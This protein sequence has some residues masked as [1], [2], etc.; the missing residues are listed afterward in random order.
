MESFKF[1]HVDSVYRNKETLLVKLWSEHHLQLA[2]LRHVDS[3]S[4]ELKERL[5][6][7]GPKSRVI[8]LNRRI[9]I[10]DYSTLM[11]QQMF[12]FCSL[13][14]GG[15]GVTVLDS[16][17]ALQQ[18]NYFLCHPKEKEVPKDLE[19]EDERSLI[20]S[21]SGGESYSYHVSIEAT[22][23][24]R[25]NPAYVN[26]DRASDNIGASSWDGNLV[27]WF[28]AGFQ[29]RMLFAFHSGLLPED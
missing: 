14:R 28:R 16:E 4:R 9:V 25:N 15:G 8:L 10:H 17:S 29:S 13:W 6:T 20:P 11:T 3:L 12:P 2:N 7:L 21:P 22:R 27:S 26:M 24:W 23:I 1:I 19:H 18:G 5:M